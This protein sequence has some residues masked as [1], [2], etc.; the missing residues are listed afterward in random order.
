[1]QQQN[2]KNHVRRDTEFLALGVLNLTLF[3]AT[4]VWVLRQ[5]N[6]LHWLLAGLALSTMSAGLAARRY[7]IRNQDRLIRLEEN[8]RLH[9]MGI[10]PS[11]LTMRQ[12]IALRFASDAEIPGLVQRSVAEKLTGKQIKE[13][14]VNWRADVDRV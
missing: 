8:V 2:L 3:A 13:A 1:M 14:I 7:A 4:A 6:P 5:P 11:N 10:D 9:W 12:M